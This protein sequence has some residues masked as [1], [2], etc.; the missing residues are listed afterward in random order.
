M[1][2]TREHIKKIIPHIKDSVISQVLPIL[3]ETIK[4]FDISNQPR[5]AAFIATLA[6]ESAGFQYNQEIWGPTAT[7]KRY[8]GRKDLG[9]THKG[10]G[11]KFKGRGRI[12]I[13]GRSNYEACGE[14]F[15]VDL[16]NNPDLLA[17]EPLATKSAG[18]FFA[19]F[20][21]LNDLA[22]KKQ[23]L[24]LEIRVN[25][26]NKKTGK[27]NGWAE[28]LNY[29]NRALEV[30]PEDFDINNDEEDGNKEEATELTSNEETNSS[31]NSEEQLEEKETKPDKDEILNSAIINKPE[32]PHPNGWSTWKTTLT[33]IWTSLGVSFAALV[34]G[35]T[36][37][38]H[39]PILAKIIVVFG[40]SVVLV[41]GLF[42]IIYLIIRT[43][44]ISRNEKFA[45][46]IQLKEMEI[47]SNPKLENVKATL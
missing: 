33:G 39:D 5:V 8:E 24:A 17:E 14:Y 45:H 16:L 18:W 30:I 7:Q 25:G 32:T 15:G 4:E 11:I 41:G 9:N 37:I 29:Y 19:G 26:K 34:T 3:N 40:L 23:F 12:Q 22:D 43:I 20:K 2:L 21:S 42:G 1:N 44:H 13:T 38:V 31:L 47:R 46:E 36:K 6:V 27:P 35:L 28:R 10:D